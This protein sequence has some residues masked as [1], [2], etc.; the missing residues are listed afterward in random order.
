[1]PVIADAKRGDIGNTAAAYARALFDVW[2]FDAMTANAYGGYDS[3]EPFIN[4]A[5]RGV[6]IWCRSPTRRRR[7]ARPAGD[8][9][10]RE[11]RP[12]YDSR[13]RKGARLE[14][15]GK[16]RRRCPCNISDRGGPPARPL[17]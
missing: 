1:M 17:P 7:P 10:R 16:R 3:V 6:F 8:R 2:G 14:Q 13:G 4:R 12:L 11:R 5:D 9:R 15:R